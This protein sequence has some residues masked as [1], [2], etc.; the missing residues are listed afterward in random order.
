MGLHEGENVCLFLR[1][2]EQ[3]SLFLVRSAKKSLQEEK[4]HRSPHVSSGS[5]LS[6]SFVVSLR[7]EVVR[8]VQEILHLQSLDVVA[9][10]RTHSGV[11]A[12][13]NP[14]VLAPMVTA[15]P[16]LTFRRLLPRWLRMLKAT[17][18]TPHCA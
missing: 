7:A 5:L 10:L 6:I 8:V 18:S 13:K 4:S 11:C 1:L 17:N 9:Y 15:L 2:R 16:G 12:K 3:K 14:V